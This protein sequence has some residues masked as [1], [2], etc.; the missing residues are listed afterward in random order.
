MFDKVQRNLITKFDEITVKL[1]PS[2]PVMKF[3]NITNPS[4]IVIEDPYKDRLI[5]N[6]TTFSLELRNLQ[7][8]DSGLYTYEIRWDFNITK[9]V[10][11]LSVLEPVAAPALT[12]NWSSS[13]SCDLTVTCR[14]HDLSLTFSCNRSSCTQLGDF[15]ITPT[16]VVFAR[17]GYVVCNHSNQVSWRNITL[18]MPSLC[19]FTREEDSTQWTVGWMTLLTIGLI[20]AGIAAVCAVIW[21]CRKK[22]RITEEARPRREDGGGMGDTRGNTVYYAEVFS[23]GIVQSFIQ[24]AKSNQTSEPQPEQPIIY[25]L[26]QPHRPTQQFDVH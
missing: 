26:L 24:D 7:K 11:K 22:L 4:I 21:I 3:V 13:N 14:G 12:S 19:K 17:D 8:N 1:S 20:C 10:Y 9:V 25:S 6:T 18:D 15:P 2:H 5:F 16:L 23:V